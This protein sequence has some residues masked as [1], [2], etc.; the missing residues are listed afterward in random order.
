MKVP[1][2][3]DEARCIDPA[4]NSKKFYRTIAFGTVAVFQWGRIGTKGQFKVQQCNSEAAARQVCSKKMSAKLGEYTASGSVDFQLE[5]SVVSE[6]NAT[7][8][9]NAVDAKLRGL[10]D[11]VATPSTPTS[12][13][14]QADVGG[15]S[16]PSGT[17]ADGVLELITARAVT[18]VATAIDDPVAAR[19]EYVQMNE[20]WEQL[21]EAIERAKSYRATIDSLLATV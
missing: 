3:A 15:S 14:R 7:H 20:E 19:I 1:V 11:Y 8:L 2:H 17:T 16:S 4:R 13:G 5:N 10:P 21:E 18:I 12:S 9:A 6:S